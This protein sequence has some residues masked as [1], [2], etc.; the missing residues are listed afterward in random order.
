MP[1]KPG[2]D[3]RQSNPE[4]TVKDYVDHGAFDPSLKKS[5]GQAE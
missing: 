3:K 1:L 5:K 2:W 4:K